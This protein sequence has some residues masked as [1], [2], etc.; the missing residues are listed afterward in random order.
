MQIVP[1]APP[2][3]DVPPPAL[4][5]TDVAP[6]AAPAPEPFLV[7]VPRTFREVEALRARRTE[8]SNQLESAAGR[9]ASLAARLRDENVTGADRTGLEQRLRVLDDRIVQLESDM[10]TTGRQLTAADPSLL[11]TRQLA[12]R[13]F[14]PGPRGVM[15]VGSFVSLAVLAPVAIAWARLLWR[16]GS[17][18]PAVASRVEAA[19]D[20]RLARLETAVDAIAIEVE[21]IA[22][23]QRFVTRLI[24]E[25]RAQTVTARAE[26]H[27]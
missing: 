7:G 26:P 25:P 22:E 5:P 16:R 4:P 9:R 17:R 10:A 2:V 24:A 8:L 19:R 20:E 21:R 3:P 13:P 12:P 18:G 14:D 6:V 1:P 23:G 15:Q 11:T 27:R